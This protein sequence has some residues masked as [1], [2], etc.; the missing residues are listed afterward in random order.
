MK[1]GDLVVYYDGLNDMSD[2]P[3]LVTSVKHWTDPGAPDRNFGIDVWVLWRNGDRQ[4][5]DPSE[6][7]YYD[8][9][10]D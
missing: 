7:R 4:V 8:E 5:F 3:G 10:S 1:V 9:S 6:L 2:Q